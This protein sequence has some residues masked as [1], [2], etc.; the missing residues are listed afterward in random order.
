V[1][2]LQDLHRP[3]LLALGTHRR[4]R[5]N[6]AQSGCVAASITTHGLR[7]AVVGLMKEPSYQ[8]HFLTSFVL[9]FCYM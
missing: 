4:G 5:V 1:G 3:R 8:R 9:T 6:V 7:K 2:I